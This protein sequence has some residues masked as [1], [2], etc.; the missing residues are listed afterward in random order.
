MIC[1]QNTNLHKNFSTDHIEFILLNS[2]CMAYDEDA[3]YH[4]VPSN[5]EEELFLKRNL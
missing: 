4:S 3:H 1:N 2:A 5:D